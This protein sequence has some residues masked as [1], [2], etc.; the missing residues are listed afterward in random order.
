MSQPTYFLHPHRPGTRTNRPPT[1][2]PEIPELVTPH[3]DNTT[4]EDE[5][6]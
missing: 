5:N 2:Y 6:R 4:R 1:S 3:D